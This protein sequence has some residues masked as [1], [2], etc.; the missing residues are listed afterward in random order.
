[1]CKEGV[2]PDVG[3][4]T[5]LPV[6]ASRLFA[7]AGYSAEAEAGVVYFSCCPAQLVTP[8]TRLMQRWFFWT[9]WTGTLPPN[10]F[11]DETDPRYFAAMERLKLEQRRVEHEEIEKIRKKNGA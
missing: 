2:R 7:Q 4:P 3:W 1:M 8:F 6:Y 10:A 9:E 5:L 11:S